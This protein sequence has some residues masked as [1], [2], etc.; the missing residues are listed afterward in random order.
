MRQALV[1]AG[2]VVHLV[3]ASDA[4]LSAAA[5]GVDLLVLAVPDQAVAR[6]AASVHPRPDTLV[7]HLAGALNLDVLD[8]HPRRASLHPLVALDGSDRLRGAWMAVA[9]DPSIAE[10]VAAL[11]GRPL[12]VADADRARYHAA[13]VVAANHLVALMGQV[14]RLAASCGLPL[15]PFVELARGAL[16]DVAHRG[17]AA[18][19]TG[20]VARGDWD[21]VR[22]H[23]RAL[24]EGDRA[25]YEALAEA[26][27]QLT[28]VPVG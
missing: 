9:G 5:D 12:T 3:P 16:E 8:P 21:T 18:A 2:W 23:L 28:E 27:A 13:A 14:E 6:V 4:D 17:P 7:I 11:D 20:P 15:D 10:V 25:A 26:A 19:L 24:P 1:R 22:A